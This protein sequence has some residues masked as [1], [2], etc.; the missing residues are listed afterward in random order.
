VTPT[1]CNVFTRP[2]GLGFLD[3]EPLRVARIRAVGFGQSEPHQLGTPSNLKCPL[4]P[5]VAR[6]AATPSSSSWTDS[7]SG[8]TRPRTVR[9]ARTSLYHSVDAERRRREPQTAHG[10]RLVSVHR[11]VKGQRGEWARRP[12]REGSLG[13]R[14]NPHPG[15]RRTGPSRRRPPTEASGG[16]WCSPRPGGCRCH[17]R[18][19]PTAHGWEC[20]H[21]GVTGAD[22]DHASLTYLGFFRTLRNTRLCA[23]ATRRHRPASRCVW[24]RTSRCGEQDQPLDRLPSTARSRSRCR[25]GARQGDQRV[26]TMLADR[27]RRPPPGRGQSSSRCPRPVGR[28]GRR[29]RAWRHRRPRLRPGLAVGWVRREWGPAWSSSSPPPLCRSESAA[30]GVEVA[31]PSPGPEDAFASTERPM[32]GPDTTRKASD[33]CRPRTRAQIRPPSWTA[34]STS[35][36][37]ATGSRSGRSAR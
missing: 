10:D 25:C 30:P 8:S 4:N 28:T 1:L 12:R 37:P 5:S 33:R 29:V 15:R 16:G 24:S 17:A 7:R 19:A 34:A 2:A 27:P 9:H 3:L 22:V 35:L 18:S 6:G 32:H 23:D 21:H 26:A 14:H 36:P 13:P 31:H 11:R 20:S